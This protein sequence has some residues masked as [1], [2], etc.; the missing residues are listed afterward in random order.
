MTRIALMP[1]V[2]SLSTPS[3]ASCLHFPFL[4]EDNLISLRL[5][6]GPGDSRNGRQLQNCR[7]CQANLAHLHTFH[8]VTKGIHYNLQHRKYQSCKL[9]RYRHKQSSSS[10]SNRDRGQRVHKHRITI[11]VGQTPRTATAAISVY[12]GTRWSGRFPQFDR[13]S[14]TVYITPS[15]ASS[16]QAGVHVSKGCSLLQG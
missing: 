8:L 14:W 1:L 15:L 4:S 10:S 7:P 11:R 2:S 6:P 12:T 13:C 3:L 5:S 16:L 9:E